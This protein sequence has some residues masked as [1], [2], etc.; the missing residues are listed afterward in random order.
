MWASQL[1]AG[2][3]RTIKMNSEGTVG[4]HKL[5]GGTV[6]TALKARQS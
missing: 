4:P 1:D 5:L 6:E 2:P 3:S